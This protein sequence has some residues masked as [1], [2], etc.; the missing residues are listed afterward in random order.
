MFYAVYTL[1]C[2]PNAVSQQVA[3]APTPLETLAGEARLREG[4]G[5]E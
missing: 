2:T 3:D 1:V 4:Q 5:D